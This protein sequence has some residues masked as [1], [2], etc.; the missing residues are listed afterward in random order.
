MK[1]VIKRPLALAAALCISGSACAASPAEALPAPAGET[2]VQTDFVISTFHCVPG[3]LT[4]EY[5]QLLTLAKE[6]G[7]THVE[8]TFTAPSASQT[9][10][11]IAEQIGLKVIVQDYTRFGGFQNWPDRIAATTEDSAKEAVEMFDS[12]ALAGYYIWDEPF[13]EQFEQVRQDIGIMDRLDPGKIQLVTMLQSYSPDYTWDNGM[14]KTYLDRYMAEV[15]PPLLVFDYYVFD[16]D[17]DK[18]VSLYDSAMWKDMGYIRLK[19]KEADIPYWFYIQLIGDIPNNTPGTMTVPRVAVQD[20]IS[21]AFGV[22]GIS[23]YNAIEGIFDDKGNKNHLYDGVAALNR[24]ILTLGRALLGAESTL[25][26]HT[27]SLQHDDYLDQLGDSETVETVPAD[28]FIGEFNAPDGGQYLLPVNTDYE[29]ERSGSIRLKASKTVYRID[30]ATG[31]PVLVAESTDAIDYQMAAG[32]GELYWLTD[33]PSDPPPVVPTGDQPAASEPDS[34]AETGGSE[35]GIPSTG[36]EPGASPP[37]GL[38]AA[39][40][41]GGAVLLGGAGIVCAYLYRRKTM[42]KRKEPPQ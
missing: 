42:N 37:I 31:Q 11:D 15:R 39:L 25:V 5:P 28:L 1:K 4:P 16:H 19:A 33:L 14:Y 2:L 8:T 13:L 23:Y 12:P 35:S 7:L 32:E 18:G 34:P 26:Y 27:S 21:L 38:I 24:D 17:V 22:S 3:G 30:K 41:L 6:A 29:K 20:Y 9:V 40:V 10:L 36:T